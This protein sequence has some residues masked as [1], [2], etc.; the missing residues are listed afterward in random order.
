M[1]KLVSL[2]SYNDLLRRPTP[3]HKLP[4]KPVSFMALFKEAA[5]RQTRTRR[6]TPYWS[7]SLSIFRFS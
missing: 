6:R 2:I 7:R 4:A 1:D 3:G 5:A